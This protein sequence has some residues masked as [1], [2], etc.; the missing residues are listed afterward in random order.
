MWQRFHLLSRGQ[1]FIVTLASAFLIAVS[2]AI[3][4]VPTDGTSMNRF[5]APSREFDPLMNSGP[6]FISVLAV[7]IGYYHLRS[8]GALIGIGISGLV[9]LLTRICGFVLFDFGMIGDSVLVQT[10]AYLAFCLLIAA[11]IFVTHM[12]AAKHHLR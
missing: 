10:C 3:V 1:V 9:F 8:L 2:V 7:L 11:L 5:L 12:K 4:S 6:A